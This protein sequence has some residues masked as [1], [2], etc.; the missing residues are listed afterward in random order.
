MSDAPETKRHAMRT[1]GK[2]RACMAACQHREPADERRAMCRDASS[3]VASGGESNGTSLS[4]S[5]F[6]CLDWHPIK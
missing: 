5:P 2:S 3:M 1:L 4:D 6:K